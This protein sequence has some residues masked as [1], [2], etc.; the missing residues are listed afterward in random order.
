M[1][2]NKMKRF[3]KIFAIIVIILILSMIA[4]FIYL[5]QAHAVLPANIEYKSEKKGFLP[6][7]FTSVR[8]CWAHDENNGIVEL[9]LEGS[10]IERG[11]YGGILSDSLIVRQERAFVK[12][13]K[14]FVHSDFYLKFL[15]YVIAVFNKN[16]YEAIPDEYK[17][18]IYGISLS[19]SP[20]FDFIA[21]SYPRILNYHGAHD[22]GHM[23]QNLGMVGCTS[24]GL[25]GEKTEDGSLLVGRNFDFYLGDEFL[26]EKIVAF[27]KPDSGFRHAFITWGGM[28][29]AVSGM[30]EKG[31][32]VSINAANSKMTFE[33][34][35]PVSIVARHILQ[36]AW[37]IKSAVEIASRYKV[38][39]SEQ[40]LIGSSADNKAVV[41]E[42]NSEQQMVYY[43]TENFIAN[44]NHF[45]S[46][47]MVPSDSSSF[48]DSP[49]IYRLARL[50]KH[51]SDVKRI[52]Y[53]DIAS[54]LRDTTAIDHRNLGI[55]NEKA[56][57]QFIA[58]HSVIFNPSK[59]IFWISTSPH[60][61]GKYLAYDLKKVFDMDITKHKNVYSVELNIPADS[62][63]FNY[64]KERYTLYLKGKDFLKAGNEI[65][66]DSF[67]HANP[68]FYHTYELVAD[69]YKNM[70]D[71]DKAKMYYKKSLSCVLPG[72]REQEQLIE[73]LAECI[74]HMKK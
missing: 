56:I 4:Y 44:T 67:I 22:L 51:I 58:H 16:I 74:K 52:S 27:I 57:N 28:M 63:L 54:I 13:I 25:W 38:F 30:N 32:T 35:T 11:V 14:K 40:F 41:I 29:G 26:K 12:Q 39:V 23:L 68:Y 70:K 20:D 50:N 15:K 73:K 69:Y 33:T 62:S 2:V 66:I 61:M 65:D 5:G 31:I 18:E 48:V 59:L 60:Q 6:N 64:Y 53:S 10:P 55:G 3:F 8:T 34:A 72:I 42:K 24:F 71:Y 49:S 45:Q 21:P 7:G 43:P 47:G 19:A 37:D 9:C 17:A 36:Y 1:P 46:V